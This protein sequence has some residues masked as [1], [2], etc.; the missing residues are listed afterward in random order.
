LGYG[1]AIPH[2]KTDGISTST[3]A[4]CKL[5]QPVAWGSLDNL[6]VEFVILLAM[7]ATGA[8]NEHLRV[9]S[10]LARKLMNEEF[11][12]ALLAAHDSTSIVTYLNSELEINHNEV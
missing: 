4:I 6:P 8:G 1:F 7:R 2:C 12:Q 10:K 9:F 5:A 3:L 11:R